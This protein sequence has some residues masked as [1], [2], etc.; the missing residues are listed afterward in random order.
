MRKTKKHL[1]LENIHVDWTKSDRFVSIAKRVDEDE[2]HM[3]LAVFYFGHIGGLG[4][5][6]DEVLSGL[7]A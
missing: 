1:V 2:A 5:K 3:A 6:K 7:Q 4:L